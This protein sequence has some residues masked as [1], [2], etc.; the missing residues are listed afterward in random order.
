MSR[1]NRLISERSLTSKL[2][3]KIL[4]WTMLIFFFAMVAI[5]VLTIYN[6]KKVVIKSGSA[7]LENTILDIEK[8]LVDVESATESMAWILTGEPLSDEALARLTT[9]M[10]RSD[11]S[12]IAAAVAY[13]PFKS[14]NKK[15]HYHMVTSYI[16]EGS[17]EIKATTL[18][19]TDYDYHI[20]DWYQIPRLLGK[21][22]WSEPTFDNATSQ[23]VTSYSK[24]LYNARGE[25]IGIIKSDV[26]LSWLTEKI[27]SLK[28]YSSSYT[29][30]V[31]RNGKYISHFRKESILNETIFS[32]AL[33]S[34]DTDRLEE[35]KQLMSGQSGVLHF[36]GEKGHAYAFYGPLKNGWTAVMVCPQRVLFRASRIINITLFII[37]LLGLIA[38]YL[39][40]R[41]AISNSMMPITEFTYA[42]ST[43]AKGNFD[44]KIPTVDTKDEIRNLHDSLLYLQ[45]SIKEYIS[46]LRATLI[47][48]QK[49]ESELNIASAIQRNMLPMEFPVNDKF[50][51]YAF[52]E[53]AREVGGDLYDFY[54][55]DGYL[56]FAIGDVC[57]K[58]VPA[59]IFMAITRSA[60]R[61]V[62]GLG[63]PMA[64]VETNINNSFSEGNGSGMFVTMFIARINLET[65]H[66]EYCNAGH[67]PIVIIR[68]DGTAYFLKAKS[69]IAAGLF[70][71]FEYEGE[72]LQLEKGSRLLLYTDGISEAENA[73]KDIFGEERLLNYATT[74]DSRLSSREFSD[75]LLGK[76]RE[77][78]AG[79]E[80]NDDITILSIKL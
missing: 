41:G 21:S 48:N 45:T 54:V 9:E 28:P 23:M 70:G 36:K 2:T 32:A 14:V 24:P 60:Y 27:S 75:G 12:T 77:F 62:S 58:G 38:L 34:G 16:P 30:L 7:T 43:M 37:A 52:L 33:A 17:D 20:L 73:G 25:F 67:N 61:F 69:N 22:Y 47:S 55:K 42:A 8:V 56:Y 3:K 35:S 6:N 29:L 76:V 66:M 79:N 63:M 40:C 74:A 78:T 11:T 1:N 59:A 10:V 65:Y 4:S 31:G 57:G 19:S 5:A 18:G 49:F 50:D 80:Q 39:S 51:L 72:E 68:P 53:P 15:D 64:Q 26:A 44:T 13:E 71:S 46:E